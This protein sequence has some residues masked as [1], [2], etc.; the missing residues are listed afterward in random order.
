MDVF[1][2]RGGT[3][4]HGKVKVSGSKNS[5]LP[6]F[7]AALLTEEE[8]ILENVPDLSDVK[9]MGEILTELGAKVDLI[10]SN[11][12]KI[13]A[14]SIVH[15]APYELVRKMRASICLLGP[16]VAR[17]RKAEIPMPG[18]CV[19]GNRPIDLHVRALEGLGAHVELSGGIVKVEGKNITGNSI[20]IGGRHGSTVT[21]TANA[22]MLAVLTPGQTIL[23]GSACEPEIADLCSMLQAMGANISGIG[24]HRLEIEGVDKL[25]GC[26]H[27]VIPDRIEA[28]TYIL[29]GA[30]TGGNISVEGIEAAHLGSFFD[31]LKTAGLPFTCKFD[32]TEISC[33]PDVLHPIEAVTLPYP[34]FPTDLQAQICALACVTPGL[35]VITERV[36]PSRFMH[37]P[38]LLRMGAHI[39]VEGSSA[40]IRGTHKLTGA[41]VMASDLRAS[42]ALILAGLAAEGETWVQR[43]YHLDRGYEAFEQKLKKLGAMVERLPESALPSSISPRHNE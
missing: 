34:G 12:W 27:T 33:P 5:A 32:G 24:S 29:A 19:I 43:I 17:L 4:L 23:E 28:G 21:G 42:A 16:L 13:R 1:Q 26:K 37:V 9:F 22:V 14:S 25:N 15:Y 10:D 41:P 30:I 7:A 2:I 3:P 31:L 8:I 6:L 18:G 36:Y 40:I 20:F 11:T 39:S 38:E 35:S